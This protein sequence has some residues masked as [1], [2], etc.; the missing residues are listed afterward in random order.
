MPKASQVSPS[1][2]ERVQRMRMVPRHGGTG[3]NAE[4]GLRL[5]L[6]A[7]CLVLSL[8]AGNGL[9]YYWMLWRDEV[10]WAAGMKAYTEMMQERLSKVCE[11]LEVKQ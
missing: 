6:I 11:Q 10:R 4:D 7:W 9:A 3:M 1:V 8:L 2:G 5:I